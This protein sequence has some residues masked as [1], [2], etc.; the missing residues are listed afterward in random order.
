M[1]IY[2]VSFAVKTDADSR[3]VGERILNTLH[4]D[5]EIAGLCVEKYHGIPFERVDPEK[6]T[7]FD[8][9]DE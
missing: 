1:P 6:V 5:F 9:F 7:V 3:D 2:L 8:F 4:D